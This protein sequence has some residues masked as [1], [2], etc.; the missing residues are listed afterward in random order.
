VPSDSAEAERLQE[1]ERL[2][3]EAQAG[4][5][6]ALRPIFERYTDPLFGGVILPRLRDAATA[7]DILRE[8]FLT[9]MEKIGQFRWEGRSI[10]AWLRQIAINKVVDVHRRA[11]RSGR[12][13]SALADES[14][15]ETSADEAADHTLIAEEQRRMDAVRIAAAMES[16]STRYRQAIELRLIEELPREECARRM[17]VTLGNFDVLLFRAIRAF[18]KQFGDPEG[19]S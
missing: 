6:M 1:E 7:E 8:T 18:R 17:N 2:I 9:A 13:M 19:E 14:P 16:I 3:A 5:I 11:K 15:H 10:Y 4:N 12:A